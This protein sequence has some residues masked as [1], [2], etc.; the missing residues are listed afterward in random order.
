MPR[1]LEFERRFG[2]VIRGLRRT[3][4][5]EHLCDA[6]S[7]GARYG[8]FVS[9]SGGMRELT[10]ALT[11]R[12][13]RNDTIQLN[14]RVERVRPTISGCELSQQSASTISEPLDVATA[15]PFDAVIVAAPAYAAADMLAASD[16][17]LAALLRR[18][19]YASTAVVVSGHALADVRHPL[20]AFGL[21]VPAVEQRKIL[22]VSFTSRKFPGRAPAGRVLLRTFVGG[23]MQPDLF[24]LP[25]VDMVN[26]ARRELEEIL[27]VNWRPDFAT[28]AW[29]ARAMPQYHVGHLRLVE[30]IEAAATR[31]PRLFLA[32][33][34]FHGVGLPDCIQSGEQAAERAVAAL[35]SNTNGEATAV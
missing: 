34:A 28:V 29:H 16:S 31:H 26:L 15:K 1:F 14:T 10:A 20:D 7:S 30:E 3:S 5:T 22:A 24:D 19:E 21:V 25:D 6:A 4:K 12:I 8:L 33:N 35:R 17:G 27:G 2:S 18:I 32:G 9:L 13:R 11:D 23:A